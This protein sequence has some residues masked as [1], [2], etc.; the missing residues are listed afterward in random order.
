MQRIDALIFFLSV[1]LLIYFR[2]WINPVL[3]FVAQEPVFFFDKYFFREFLRFP[4]GLLEYVSAL[5]AQFF[6]TPWPGALLL[7]LFFTLIFILLRQVVKRITLF[8]PSALALVPLLFLAIAHND[9][10][11][12]LVVDLVLLTALSCTFIYMSLRRGMRILFLLVGGPLLYFAAGAA[13]LLFGLYALVYEILQKRDWLLSILILL[14]AVLPCASGLWLFPVRL[15]DAFW[16]PAFPDHHSAIRI[17]AYLA[18]AILAVLLFFAAKRTGRLFAQARPLWRIIPA[19]I[20]LLLFF[21]LPALRLD[22]MEKSYWQITYHART[23]EWQKL[24]VRCEKPYPNAPQITSLINRA[25]CHTGQMG[26][27]LFSYPQD[28]GLEG[29]FPSDDATISTPLIRSDIYF[30]LRHFN[31]AKHWAHEAVSVTGETAWNMQRLALIYLIDEQPEAAQLYITKL[32]KSIPLRQWARRHEQYV[33]NIAAVKDDPEIGPLLRSRVSE[34]FLSFVNNPL[35]D[36]PRLLHADPK[37]KAAYDYWMAALLLTKRLARFVQLAD[38]S[39]AKPL[40][41]HF[42]EAVLIYMSQVHDHGLT[43]DEKI[44]SPETLQ[45]YRTFQSS[46]QA[47]RDD[48]SAA[49]RELAGHFADTY[50]YYLIFHKGPGA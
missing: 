26:D 35:A 15:Q 19:A 2:Y 11:H 33:E 13:F 8:D 21:I 43:F 22:K 27:R 28:F 17:L 46:L 41:R 50:W 9:Y 30:D 29:L 5:L 23:Q 45:R 36:L 18:A 42:Q 38:L 24:L 16:Q 37:N 6:Y 34:S 48:R 32:K 1:G 3:Y 49:Q 10:T 25:L 44:F 4:G 31:E 39:R 40:P 20:L 7:S 47:S 12:P 14:T